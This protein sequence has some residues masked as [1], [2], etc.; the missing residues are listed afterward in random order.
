[1]TERNMHFKWADHTLK[2]QSLLQGVASMLPFNIDTER[3]IRLG[4]QDMLVGNQDQERHMAMQ[5]KKKANPSVL[6]SWI[7]RLV[8]KSNLHALPFSKGDMMDLFFKK[9]SEMN[10]SAC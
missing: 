4:R 3:I 1:M 2:A 5:S 7:R 8:L 9:G 6:L 10:N